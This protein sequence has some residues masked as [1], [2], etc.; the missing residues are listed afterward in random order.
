MDSFLHYFD[1][2]LW[3]FNSFLKYLQMSREGRYYSL[4][5]DSDKCFMSKMKNKT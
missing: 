2:K 1:P 4:N 3:T 5:H